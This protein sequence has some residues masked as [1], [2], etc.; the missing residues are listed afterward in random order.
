ME[1]FAKIEHRERARDGKFMFKLG[2]IYFQQ[3]SI[4]F[5]ITW[6]KKLKFEIGRLHELEQW[7][8]VRNWENYVGSWKYCVK[9]WEF[10]K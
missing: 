6:M 3:Y 7:D 10:L 1:K 9:I 2:T 4:N 8:I 5:F